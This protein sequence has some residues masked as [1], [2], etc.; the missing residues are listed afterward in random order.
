M[1]IEERVLKKEAAAASLEAQKS[2][3]R[4]AMLHKDPFASMPF[5]VQKM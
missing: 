5:V 1:K 3:M 4:S 2:A